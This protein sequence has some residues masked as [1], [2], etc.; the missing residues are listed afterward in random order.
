MLGQIASRQ[1]LNEAANMAIAF[2]NER[3]NRGV[4]VNNAPFAQYSAGYLR[5]KMG[6]TKP[7]NRKKVMNRYSGVVDLQLTGDMMKDMKVNITRTPSIGRFETE[8][9]YISGKS[10]EASIRKANWHNLSGAGKGKVLRKFLGLTAGEK[11][12]ILNWF[13]R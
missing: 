3:T 9:G 11:D 2:I 1:R 6:Q 7:R 13:Q 10:R 8:I 4:D 12:I 5:F